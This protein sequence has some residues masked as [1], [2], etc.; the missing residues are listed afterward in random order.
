MV[1]S[2]ARGH[3]CRPTG[4][5]SAPSSVPPGTRRTSPNSWRAPVGGG[6]HRRPDP[7]FAE[8]FSAALRRVACVVRGDCPAEE[9]DEALAT[10]E[11]ALDASRFDPSQVTV[12]ASAIVALR[13][14]IESEKRA[15]E[16]VGTRR[17][18]S[19][20]SSP[21][22]DRALRR[23]TRVTTRPRLA[24]LG[25]V[26]VEGPSG[27]PAPITAPRP[28]FLTALVLAPGQTLSSG[29]LV[30][31]LWPDEQPRDARAALQT[32][33][34]RLRRSTAA[35]LVRSTAT[36]YALGCDAEDVDLLR[37]ER[38]ASTTDVQAL[39]GAIALWRGAPGEDVDGD[40]GDALAD[41]AAAAHGALRR[42]LG[43]GPA[44]DRAGGRGGR[45]LAVRHRGGPLR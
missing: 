25:S 8:P 29:S 22:G 39:E 4:P 35:G 2:V 37:A 7:A 27:E 31:E 12:T 33:V 18:R 44:R 3:G 26:L 30:D 32:M 13:G 38:L 10:L 34:S 6:Q 40:L 11:Q 1:R 16:D 14:V 36:G 43:G 23:L 28:S 45:G 24:V 9:G 21:G 41:R 19:G 5:G 20:R 15:T 17:G 42:S